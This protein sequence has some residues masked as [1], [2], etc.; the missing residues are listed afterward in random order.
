MTDKQKFYLL[1]Q[2]AADASSLPWPGFRSVRRTGKPR[3]TPYYK[4]SVRDF[5]ALPSSILELTTSSALAGRF[6]KRMMSAAKIIRQ[7]RLIAST[8]SKPVLVNNPPPPAEPD[9]EDV[10]EVDELLYVEE[11]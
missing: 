2:E 9:V 4:Q 10:V 8:T 11:P 1:L 7:A 5:S 6:Q 3:R